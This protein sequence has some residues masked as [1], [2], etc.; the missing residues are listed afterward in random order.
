M[1]ICFADIDDVLGPT[2]MRFFG[3]GY[4][5]VKARTRSVEQD[6]D[7]IT[8]YG[9]LEYPVAW[10][11][12]SGHERTEMH[13]SSIDAVVLACRVL[14]TVQAPSRLG[15]VWIRRIDLRAPSS[16]SAF[17]QDIPIHANCSGAE[18]LLYRVAVAGFTVTLHL[19]RHAKR[20]SSSINPTA[21]GDTWARLSTGDVH[22]HDLVVDPANELLNARAHI[23]TLRRNGWSLDSRYPDLSVADSMAIGG[24]LSQVLLYRLEGLTRDQAGDFWL[25]RA[26]ISFS[27]P[28]TTAAE[29]QSWH[30]HVERRTHVAV[31][32]H[33]FSSARLSLS[34]SDESHMLTDVAFSL[35][36]AVA[37][38]E[39]RMSSLLEGSP[40]RK[41]RGS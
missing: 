1:T 19:A 15:A 8:G 37:G 4:R 14:E 34:N 6:E 22:L 38:S 32:R 36:Q 33:V 20:A 29:S 24:A 13:V 3:D 5:K 12:R 16:P 2:Q 28:R 40:P 18:S 25:R 7:T 35:P 23:S 39:E 26:T 41:S 31:S 17:L 11:T 27:E 9:D 30:V 10:S 21:Q